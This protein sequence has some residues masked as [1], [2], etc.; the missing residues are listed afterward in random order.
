MKQDSSSNQVFGWVREN[1]V[2]TFGRCSIARESGE[3][4]KTEKLETAQ[5]GASVNMKHPWYAIKWNV[6]RAEVR[7]LQVSADSG[8]VSRRLLKVINGAR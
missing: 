2:L 4:S 8:C 5:A 3:P 1:G 7:R 6:A